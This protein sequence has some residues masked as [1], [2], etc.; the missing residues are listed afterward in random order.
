MHPRGGSSVGAGSWSLT[1]SARYTEVLNPALPLRLMT[2]CEDLP[3]VYL[4][5]GS[6]E[7]L[8]NHC[9]MLRPLYLLSC[10]TSSSGPELGKGLHTQGLSFCQCLFWTCS[11]LIFHLCFLLQPLTQ[12]QG[13]L[14]TRINVLSHRGSWAS[15]TRPLVLLE[16]LLR[17]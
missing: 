5:A 17:R 10:V 4:L 8:I 12:I 3:C 9:L 14:S 15:D 16:F 13:S 1:F 6:Q 11:V 7:V 2:N